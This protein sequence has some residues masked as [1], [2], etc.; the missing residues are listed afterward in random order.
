MRQRGG[1]GGKVPKDQTHSTSSSPRITRITRVMALAIQFQVMV[2]RVEA[3]DYA[4]LTRLEQILF[5]GG[6]PGLD[7]WTEYRL[8]DSLRPV[9]SVVDWPTQRSLMRKALKDLIAVYSNMTICKGSS[10][11]DWLS[12]RLSGGKRNSPA[13][14]C[15][16]YRLCARGLLRTA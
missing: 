16:P 2:D 12:G 8:S 14:S 13:G 11:P 4:D 1:E 3:D 10:G 9:L 7:D 6:G 15:W 5:A